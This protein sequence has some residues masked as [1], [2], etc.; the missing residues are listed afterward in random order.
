VLSE[1]K[2]KIV[3]LILS[4]TAVTIGTFPSL[5]FMLGKNEGGWSPNIYFKW[6]DKI[7][8]IRWG[9]ALVFGLA[10]TALVGVMYWKPSGWVSRLLVMFLSVLALILASRW[11]LSVYMITHLKP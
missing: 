10:G 5:D 1:R 4:T 8:Y 11:L 6:L 3:I 2:K 9:W 7:D